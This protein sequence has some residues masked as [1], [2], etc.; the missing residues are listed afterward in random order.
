MSNF[1]P[2]SAS[3]Q[4]SPLR[5]KRPKDLQQGK[6]SVAAKSLGKTKSSTKI[7]PTVLSSERVK[8]SLKFQSLIRKNEQQ[9]LNMTQGMVN[10]QQSSSSQAANQAQSQ[11][12]A[13]NKVP[14]LKLQMKSIIEFQN[15]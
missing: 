9:P 3:A 14:S 1:T 15:D 5:S 4:I 2:Q 8:D 6:N 7:D 10:S 12:A 11:N 13:A